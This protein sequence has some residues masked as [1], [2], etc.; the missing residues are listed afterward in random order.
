LDPASANIKNRPSRRK[1]LLGV[2][3][4]LLVGIAFLIMQMNKGG[5]YDK[6]FLIADNVIH[7]PAKENSNEAYKLYEKAEFG[8]AVS[9]FEKLIE[10]D[11][12]PSHKFYLA[13][14]HLQNSKYKAAQKLLQQDP[15]K[16]IKDLPINYYLALSKVGTND[17]D[18]AIELLNNP[19]LPSPK[20]DSKR[21]KIIRM[22]SR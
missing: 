12:N 4:L 21:K 8:R 9:A 15:V 19:T 17:P 20:L 11:K 3:L 22:L 16:N 18:E 14:C 7:H 10:T 5:S 1:W 2:G 6:D 13:V